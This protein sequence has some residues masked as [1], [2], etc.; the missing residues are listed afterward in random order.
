MSDSFH[1]CSL[2]L[3]ILKLISFK[4]KILFNNKDISFYKKK[5]LIKLRRLNCK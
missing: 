5:D 1:N 2:V 4:G 3:A